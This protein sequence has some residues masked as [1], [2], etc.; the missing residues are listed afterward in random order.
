MAAPTA[1]SRACPLPSKPPS[2]SDKFLYS[3]PKN[4]VTAPD[5]S[6]APSAMEIRLGNSIRP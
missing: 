1:K 3:D 2:V 6:N 5:M 4:H